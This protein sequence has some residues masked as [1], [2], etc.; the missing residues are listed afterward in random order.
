MG[1]IVANELVFSGQRDVLGAS[2]MLPLELMRADTLECCA[3]YPSCT[4]T[5]LVTGATTGK[6]GGELSLV[7]MY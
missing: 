4:T 3:R 7:A 2:G 1:T 6:I 5:G